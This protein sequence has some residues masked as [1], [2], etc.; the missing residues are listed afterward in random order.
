MEKQNNSS[1][2]GFYRTLLIICGIVFSLFFISV[3]MKRL[4]WDNAFNVLS[5]VQLYPW[6]CFSLLFYLTGHL[7]RGVR[8]RLLVSRDTRLSVLTASNIVVV[9]SVTIKLKTFQLELRF[10]HY[11]S[12]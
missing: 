4:E 1:S 5:D 10:Q 2:K 8:T 12:G 9:K 11:S 6:I 3:A 7:V